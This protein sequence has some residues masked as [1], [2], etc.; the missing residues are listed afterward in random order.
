MIFRCSQKKKIMYLLKSELSN[1]SNNLKEIE[2]LCSEKQG[3]SK[4]LINKKWGEFYKYRLSHYN[5]KIKK[6]L[7]D[8][9]IP[10]LLK[11]EGLNYLYSNK[12]GIEI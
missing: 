12:E 10:Q 2:K 6:L 5:S 3:I 7:L 8:L 11:E 4:A 1:G 9:N